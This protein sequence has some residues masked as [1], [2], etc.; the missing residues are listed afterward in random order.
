MDK[1][2][3]WSTKSPL[4]EYEAVTF[5]HPEFDAPFRLVA[6]VFDEVT[7]NGNVHTPAAMT[8]KRPETNTDGQP[9]LILAFPRQVVGRQFKQQLALIAAAGSLDPIEVLFEVYTGDTAA[10]TVSWLMYASDQGGVLFNAES[11]Q[12][13]ATLDNPMRRGVSV[14]YTPAVFTGLQTL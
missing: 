12:V 10:P 14:I 7:L 13:T 3:F 2:E 11:V 8:I 1:A 5:S 4:P 9:K 6:N